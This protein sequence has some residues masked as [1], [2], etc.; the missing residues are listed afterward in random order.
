M[1]FMNWIVRRLR[2]VSDWFYEVFLEVRGW[3]WPFYLIADFFYELSY[4]FYYLAGNFSDFGDWLEWAADEIG[5]IL[6]WSNIRSLIR[7]WLPDLEDAID[8]W[9]R[10][11]KWVGEEI[12]DWWR[13]TRQTVKGWISAA[14]DWLS[15][16][17][18]ALERSLNTLKAA[19]D[20]WKV[21]ISSFNELWLWF[22]NWW[23]N[24]LVNLDTWWND[25]LIDIS[26]LIDTAFTLREPFWAGWQDWR[27]KVVEFFTDPLG[28]L[29]ARFTDWFLG[30]EE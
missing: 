7:S 26:A 27:D 24:V 11:W 1:S 14:E 16:W 3:V 22:T 19:W 5:D 4:L 12:D 23:G 29:E 28:W 6:S 25:R 10:W 9:D 20:E 18:D 21:K 30:P 2:D 13:D 15:D 17:I 8:W